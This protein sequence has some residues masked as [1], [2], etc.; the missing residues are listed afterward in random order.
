MDLIDILR[1]IYDSTQR[2]EP[3]AHRTVNTYSKATD[4]AALSDDLPPGEVRSLLVPDP[5]YWAADEASW[6]ASTNIKWDEGIWS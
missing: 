2:Q 6:S 4:D 3:S 1:V 5:A